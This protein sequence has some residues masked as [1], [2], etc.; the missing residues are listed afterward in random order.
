MTNPNQP[1]QVPS[2]QN[3]VP[4]HRFDELNERLRTMELQNTQ[5]RTTID[6]LKQPQPGAQP[7][8][9][10]LFK[11]EVQEAIAAT[12]KSIVE[13]MQQQFRHQIGFMADQLDQ[14]R[15]SAQYG[16][17]K[18]EK[19]VPKVEQL[20]QREQAQG[21][22]IT[23]EDALRIVHFEESGKKT[24]E[25]APAAAAPAAP[26]PPR[27]DPYLQKWVTDEPA[28]QQP[29]T[30]EAPQQVQNPTP[31]QQQWPQQTQQP[32]TQQWQPGSKPPMQT[33]HPMG[34]AYGQQFTLPGQGVNQ[35]ANQGQSAAM[36]G[37]LSLD[38]SD[39]D[40]KAFES[41][42]GDIPL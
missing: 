41:Q 9:N 18:Y 10:N 7:P 1:N 26:T 3:Q 27:F 31:D 38:S 6:M 24:L 32:Q 11:P 12:V 8:P 5:L 40:M 33:N 13:P 2:L 14:T 25:P 36:K 30:Q 20:R 17:E 22:Y 37:P 15:F 28:A 35:P 29:Q 21:R 34:N 23:R 4:D 19:L 39:A 16:G 42:F